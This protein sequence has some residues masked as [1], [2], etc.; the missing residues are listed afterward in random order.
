MKVIDLIQQ[1]E[2]CNPEDGVEISHDTDDIQNKFSTVIGIN[3]IT[4]D[5]L[6]SIVILTEKKKV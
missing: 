2:K 3:E 4:K 5:R 6:G 1:L